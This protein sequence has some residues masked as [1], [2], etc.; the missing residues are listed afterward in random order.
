MVMMHQEGMGLRAR[1]G[2]LTRNPNTK[3]IV[4][5][6]ATVA[7]APVILPLV[8]PILK[9]TIKTGVTWY[10]K[11]KSTLAET[12]ESLADIAAEAKAEVLAQTENKSLPN[13]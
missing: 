7:L 6:V 11:T 12:A 5:G 9:T 10:E 3:A 1:V 8:K 2:E 4:V 13:S